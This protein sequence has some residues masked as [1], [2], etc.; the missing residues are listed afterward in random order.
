[1]EWGEE[2][3]ENLWMYYCKHCEKGAIAPILVLF[4]SCVICSIM[5]YFCS[6][7]EIQ[8]HWLMACKLV[9]PRR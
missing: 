1:M 2:G 5:K 6:T 4:S 8:P 7:T 3:E 9:M